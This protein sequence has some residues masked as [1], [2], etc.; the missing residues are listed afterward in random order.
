MITLTPTPTPK[1]MSAYLLIKVTSMS[2]NDGDP[3]HVRHVFLMLWW[4]D[5]FAAIVDC[6]INSMSLIKK[7]KKKK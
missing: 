1:E 2:S 4:G 6:V 5:V 7:K 3:L